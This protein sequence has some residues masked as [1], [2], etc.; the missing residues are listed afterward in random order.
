MGLKQYK[1]FS[2]ADIISHPEEKFCEKSVQVL[3]R[4]LWEFC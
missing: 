1:I 4:H 2:S 3:Q